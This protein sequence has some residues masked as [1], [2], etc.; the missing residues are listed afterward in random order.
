MSEL[1][2]LIAVGTFLSII[3]SLVILAEKISQYRNPVSRG[4]TASGRLLKKVG[5]GTAIFF[6]TMFVAATPFGVWNAATSMVAI[7]GLAEVIVTSIMS[8]LFLASIGLLM[9]CYGIMYAA[10]DSRLGKRFWAARKRGGRPAHSVA[11]AY[12]AT[13]KLGFAILAL[14]SKRTS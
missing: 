6:G 4:L 14:W 1:D 2:I 12:I 10:P 13:L 9:I 7:Y 8:G 5:G 11:M 3:V